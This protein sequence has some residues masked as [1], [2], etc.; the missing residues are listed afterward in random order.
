M[1][2]PG[3]ASIVQI[4]AATADCTGLRNDGLFIIR[5]Q[6]GCPGGSFM[7]NV[8]RV[9][10]ACMA[11]LLLLSCR[12]EPAA[13]TSEPGT[14]ASEAFAWPAALS[15]F[16]DGY[17]KAG[18]LCRRLGESE[19]TV[20]FLDDS[21]ILVG[22][23]GVPDDSAAAAMVAAGGKVV[24]EAQGVTIISIPQG[25]ANAG[26]AEANAAQTPDPKQ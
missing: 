19:L 15:P 1:P 17:P 21:A 26:M 4:M 8:I 5:N 9:S 16:G 11:A 23:P 3:V 22:C 2:N 7:P 14:P 18:D 20:N 25:D 6:Q 24:A 12:Q 10:V 13:D